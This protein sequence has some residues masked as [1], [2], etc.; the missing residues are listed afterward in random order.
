MAARKTTKPAT[1]AVAKKA[2]KKVAGSGAKKAASKVAKKVAPIAKRVPAARKTTVE[3]ASVKSESSGQ[4]ANSIVTWLKRNATKATRDGMVRYGIPAD[5]AFGVPVGVMLKYAKSLG[6]HHD[7]A[8]ALWET[9]C[10]EARM[11]ASYLSEPE[12]MSPA[13][14]DAWV[15]DFDSW[16]ICDTVCWHAFERSPYAWEKITKWSRMSGEIQ[17][18]TGVALLAT[19][20]LHIK[21]IDDE[22]FADMLSLVERAAQDERNFVSKGAN[23]ALR[24][25]GLRSERLRHDARE[26]AAQLSESENAWTRWVGK[27]ALKKLEKPIRKQ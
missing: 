11:M 16:A 12:R 13:Q 2:A 6:R 9:G 26:L 7:V 22:K 21:T 8:M 4:Q 3:K 27:D 23:W 10:Y 24:A 19:M 18:R 25:I 15:N 17:K 1:K 5:N 20:A 14:M